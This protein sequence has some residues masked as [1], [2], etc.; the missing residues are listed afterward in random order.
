MDEWM[1]AAASSQKSRA[2]RGERSLSKT[3]RETLRT[4]VRLK[5]QTRRGRAWESLGF[6][7][8]V[9]RTVNDF[10]L[11]SFAFQRNPFL[12]PT[13]LLLLLVASNH[14]DW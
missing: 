14:N 12:S 10:A 5:F 1:F 7:R 9:G 13:L 11:S 4:I 2:N 3:L 6:I 8:T